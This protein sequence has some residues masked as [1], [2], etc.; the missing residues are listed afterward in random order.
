MFVPVKQCNY[1]TFPRESKHC[2]VRRRFFRANP[3]IFSIVSQTKMLIPTKTGQRKH[4]RAGKTSPFWATLSVPILAL[5]Q[6][7]IQEIGKL[8]SYAGPLFC[9][10]DTNVAWPW[11]VWKQFVSFGHVDT[12]LL[13][14][15]AWC[16]L[17][18]VTAS[19]GRY[20]VYLDGSEVE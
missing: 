10:W 2:S 4:Y 15:S 13:P 9:C 19:L 18:R 14:L 17:L 6:G 11:A 20:K 16:F 5:P 7:Y 1:F 3:S 8:Y 12:A